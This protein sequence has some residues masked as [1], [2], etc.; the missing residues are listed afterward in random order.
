MPTGRKRKRHTIPSHGE[1]EGSEEIYESPKKLRVN[2][3]SPT[4][5]ATPGQKAARKCEQFCWTVVISVRRYI[6][7]LFVGLGKYSHKTFEDSA[8]DDQYW[9]R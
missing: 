8:E 5:D 4:T 1:D 3:T 9:S 7:I 6:C 2:A